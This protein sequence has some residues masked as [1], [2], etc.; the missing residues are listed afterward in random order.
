MKQ[1]LDYRHDFG[2]CSMC[3]TRC[4]HRP[5]YFSYKS[6]IDLLPNIESHSMFPS[7][8]SSLQQLILKPLPKV[9]SLIGGHQS[10]RF[11]IAM[12]Q[13]LIN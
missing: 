12:L 6:L 2:C 8:H 9:F 13:L 3:A 11:L 5:A 7:K 10:V 4:R 1:R